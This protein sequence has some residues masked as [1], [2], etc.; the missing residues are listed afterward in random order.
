[1]AGPQ[2]PRVPEQ[3]WLSSDVVR[4]RCTGGLGIGALAVSQ[5]VRWDSCQRL[6]YVSTAFEFELA[7]PQCLQVNMMLENDDCV[8]W[9]V[10]DTD[11]SEGFEGRAVKAGRFLIDRWCSYISREANL[12]VSVLVSVP[13]RLEVSDSGSCCVLVG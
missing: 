9:C 10:V 2:Q 5:L 12:A 8:R 6:A 4:S 3:R 7:T 11:G 13:Y 1:M